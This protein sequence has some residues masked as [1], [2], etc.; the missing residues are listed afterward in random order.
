MKS[1]K[2]TNI[3]QHDIPLLQSFIVRLVLGSGLLVI[4]L[5]LSNSIWS[6]EYERRQVVNEFRHNTMAIG[7]TV[8]P[9]ITTESLTSFTD[10]TAGNSQDFKVVQRELRRLQEDNDFTEEQVYILRKDETLENTY[11]FSVM[12]QDTLFIGDSYSPPEAVA[13]MY[14]KAWAGNPQSTPMFTDDHGTFV[15]ALVPLKNEAGDVVGIIEL[16]RDLQDYLNAFFEDIL[17]RFLVDVF[18]F[19]I[20]LV[21]GVWI[22]RQAKKRVDDLLQGTIAIQEENYEYRIPIVAQSKDEFTLLGR[23]I[24]ISLSQ[25]G[26]RFSMLKFLPK[27]TLKMIAYANEQQSIVDL[28][29]V[30]NVECVIMETDI[31]GFTALTQSLSPHDTIKL[32]NEYIEVQAEIIIM[33]EYNGSIDKYMGDAVLVIFEGDEKE[34]RA[35]ECAHHIQHS[36][37]HLNKRRRR[38]ARKANKPHQEV[39]IGIGLSMGRVIM[40]NMGCDERMEHT[41]IGS[42]VNLAARLCSA[43]K[44][45]EIVVHQEILENIGKQGKY[46]EIQVK[47]FSEPVAIRRLSKTDTTSNMTYCRGIQPV[48]AEDSNNAGTDQD[49]TGEV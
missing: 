34:R 39:E 29:M 43:A 25:L 26:E 1:D 3:E 28:N 42:T 10:N 48:Q 33:E 35:Y 38:K 31:R 24:N 18:F 17:V 40:G 47:G 14:A 21:L 7:L 49:P 5:M 30:R 12:L 8:A 4:A 15:A 45:G 2:S 23:A 32:I 16:D 9:Y 44:G 27:H 6:Y 11:R 13:D 19:S 22:Y 41:V 37:R 20:W 36:L 46:E